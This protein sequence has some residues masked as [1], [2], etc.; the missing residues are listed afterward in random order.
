MMK[1]RPRRT[2]SDSSSLSPIGGLN[3][4]F[5][6]LIVASRVAAAPA[7]G[8]ENPVRVGSKLSTDSVILGEIAAQLVRSSGLEAEHLRQL[9]G[10][11]ILFNALLNGQIDLYPEYTGT[12]TQQLLHDPQLQ[13]EELI[14]AA[15]G[16]LGIGMTD[17]LGFSNNYAIGMRRQRAESLHLEEVVRSSSFARIA[18]RIQQ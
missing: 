8:K 13:N 5:L 15:L 9:G 11:E 14:R 17:P 12:I 7:V 3:L 4:F 2:H 1:I 10:T 18:I 6:L 16:R